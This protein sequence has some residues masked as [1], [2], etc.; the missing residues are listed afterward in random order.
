MKIAITGASGMIGTALQ[1]LLRADGHEILRLVRREPAA[2]DEAQWDPDHRKLDPTLLS[3]VDA[4]IHL[5]G[6]GV[7]DKRWTSAYKKLLVDSRVNGTSA[8]AHALA[9]A[10]ADGRQRVLLSASAVGWYGDTGTIPVEESTPVG[11]GFLADLVRQWEKATAPAADAGVRVVLMRSGLVC[12]RGGGVMGR[13]LPL[14]KAGVGGP[15]GSGKQ[16]WPWISLPDELAAIQF[17]LTAKDISGPVNLTG[18][19]PVTNAK[20]SHALGRALHRPAYL[21]V[22][23]FALRIAL[24]E[25]ADEGVLAG[26]RALPQKLVDAGF[27]FQHPDVDAAMAWIAS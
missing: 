1:P 19:T 3:D 18:P 14:F 4:V 8:V 25:F 11:D 27:S 15:M 12:G 10:A 17:L 7:G 20:F 6:V 26:Q 16:Y 24:G 13:M 21:P 2:P 22:P 9:E 23:G 5:A